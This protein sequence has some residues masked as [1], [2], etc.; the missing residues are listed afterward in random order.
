LWKRLV[1]REQ[2]FWLRRL[3]AQLCRKAAL[4][5][6]CSNADE[7]VLRRMVGPALAPTKI[8]PNGVDISFFSAPGPAELRGHI[9]FTGSMDWLPNEDAALHFL[10]EMWPVVQRRLPGRQ[11]VV[12]GRNPGP[13]LRRRA[14]RGQI[15]ITGTV[16]DIRPFLREALALVVPM[17]AG[18]GTRLKILEAFAASSPVVSSSIGIEGIEARPNIEYLAAESAAEFAD[19]LYQL[20]SNPRL[21][22]ELTVAASR[23]ARERYSWD[24]IASDLARE[25]SARFV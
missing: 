8:V 4:V 16:D 19:R 10:D 9:V 5:L 3:E 2:R 20:A 13:R 24:A 6:L 23:L 1:F 21:R 7:Q 11:F 14:E 25:Y 15:V 18:G 12:A 17:R 22:A